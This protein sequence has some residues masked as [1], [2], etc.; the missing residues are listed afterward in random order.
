MRAESIISWLTI[1][2]MINGM[3]LLKEADLFNKIMGVVMFLVCSAL[4]IVMEEVK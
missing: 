3:F 2:G 1:Y 4:Y